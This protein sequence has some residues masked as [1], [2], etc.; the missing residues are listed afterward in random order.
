MTARLLTTRDVA[1]W[2]HV[3]PETVLRRARAGEIPSFR[4]ATNALRFDEAEVAAW[5]ERT[6]NKTEAA[7]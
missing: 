2:L 6:R 7:T 3:S 5:L 4:I 1:E